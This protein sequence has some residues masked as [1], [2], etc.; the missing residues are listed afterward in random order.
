MKVL[1]FGTYDTATHPRLAVML[2]GLGL[3]GASIRELDEPLGLSTSNRVRILREPWRLPVLGGR[4][5]SRWWALARGASRYHGS[6]SPDAVLVGYMGHFD[7]LLARLLFPRSLVVLD[8]LIFASGTA[9]DRGVGRGLRTRVLSLLDRLAIGAAD[10]IVVDTREHFE[11]LP[12]RRRRDGVVVPVGA[13]RAWTDSALPPGDTA[14]TRTGRLSVV[15]FGLFTPLQGTVTIAHAIRRCREQGANVDFTLVG[16]GQDAEEVRS[17]LA[18]VA[19]IRWEAWADRDA[20]TDIVASHDVCLGI[21]GTT[22]KALNVVPNKVYQGAAAGCCVVTS[23]TEPQRRALRGGAILVPPGDAEALAAELVS[24]S[25]DPARLAEMR[26]RA[27]TV[28]RQDFTP[29]AVVD[30]LV[31]ALEARGVSIS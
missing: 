4:L 15:F 5:A 11:M 13:A 23:E 16:D 12:T 8:H 21:F 28:A 22:T 2:D 9:V 14:L 10:I 18:G 3:R 17:I 1:G 30:P 24:L 29:G 20:L 26:D 7:V 19:G 27:A 6:S 31:R 25:H